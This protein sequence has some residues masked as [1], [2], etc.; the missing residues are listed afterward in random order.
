MRC[1]VCLDQKK[2]EEL[3][4]TYKNIP[5]CSVECQ[6]YLRSYGMDGFIKHQENDLEWEEECIIALYTEM[7]TGIVLG[8]EEDGYGYESRTDEEIEKDIE[9][10]MKKRKL[11]EEQIKTL[12]KHPDV[13]LKHL[14]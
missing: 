3:N 2:K 11:L 6:E 9:L 5:I 12:K 10:R 13:R 7:E 14:F 8:M 1:I 4:F